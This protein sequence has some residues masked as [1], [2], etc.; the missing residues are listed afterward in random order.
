MLLCLLGSSSLFLPWASVIV[1]SVDP[2][3]QVDGSYKAKNMVGQSFVGYQF[4]HG[5]ASAITFLALFLLLLATGPLRPVPWWRSAVLL[6]GAMSIV[7]IVLAGLNFRH[8]VLESDL[9]GGRA[10]AGRLGFTNHAVIGL[11]A[12][13]ALLAALEMR[14][15]VAANRLGT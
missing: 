7:V 5:A 14:L 8:P 11:A 1:I 3:P 13:L 12:A 2:V 6:V 9:A 10:I 4:W 15:R